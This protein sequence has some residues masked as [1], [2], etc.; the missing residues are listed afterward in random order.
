MSNSNATSKTPSSRARIAVVVIAI[1]VVILVVLSA[2]IWPGWAR[3][4]SA[5]TSSTQQSV[6]T[7]NMVR[8]SKPTIDAVALPTDATDL[9]KALPDS[10]LNF[11]RTNV[12]KSTE[13]S[14]MSPIESYK[15]TY[16]T[17]Q[18][19][20]DVTMLIAQWNTADAAN[21]LYSQLVATHQASN[22][23]LL[24]H[25]SVKVS[26][27]ET[28]QYE[29]YDLSSEKTASDSTNN[30]SDAN[31]KSD[32]SDSN[33]NDANQSKTSSDNANSSTS[34]SGNSEDSATADTSSKDGKA[35]AI[36]QNDTVVFQVTGEKTDVTDFYAKFPM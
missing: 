19:G 34:S 3:R 9:M 33:A 18:K 10:V 21:K 24:A 5:T 29:V 25:G 28:G 17:G 16:S 22:G 27:A 6:T 23:K 30:S 35:V 15:V 26:G 36:W 32:E 2:F 1:A 20:H 11:A 8:P 4:Q 7:Q 14:D 13:W 12:E 31:N